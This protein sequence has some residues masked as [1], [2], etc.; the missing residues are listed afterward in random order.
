MTQELSLPIQGVSHAR[1]MG[2]L[3]E[4]PTGPPRGTIHGPGI[5]MRRLWATHGVATSKSWATMGD[6]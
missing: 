2:H 6:P 3:D 4:L 1:A 5:H